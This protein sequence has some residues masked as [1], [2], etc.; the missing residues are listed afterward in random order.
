MNKASNYSCGSQLNVRR[1]LNSIAVICSLAY[2]SFGISQANWDFNGTDHGWDTSNYTSL[3]VGESS[4]TLNIGQSPNPNL[5]T[6]SARID[7]DSSGYIVMRIMN[8]TINTRVQVIL[9]RNNSTPNTFT[10]YD[11]LSTN[12]LLYKSPSPRDVEESRMPSSA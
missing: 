5:G 12:C 4:A 6:M 3:E 7:A 2:S 10:G 11:G 1:F 8:Q 9:N